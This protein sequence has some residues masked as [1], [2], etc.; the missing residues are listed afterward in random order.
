MWVVIGSRMS[1]GVVVRG[2]IRGG[3]GLR[4]RSAADAVLPKNCSAC[5]RPD[6]RYFRPYR[7]RDMRVRYGLPVLKAF[8]ALLRGCI[9]AATDRGA[10]ALPLIASGI[11][12]L[13]ATQLTIYAPLG[14]T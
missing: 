11:S 7:P 3:V 6:P 4:P 13:A 14:Y 1:A 9:F 2:H 5:C 12:A 8:G 10:Q